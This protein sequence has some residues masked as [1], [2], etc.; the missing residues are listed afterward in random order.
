MNL[1]IFLLIIISVTFSA[2]AQ[3]VL[4]FGMTSEKIQ[5]VLDNKLNRLEV[6]LTIIGNTHVI[7]G[8]AIYGIGALLWLLVL[9]RLD[10]SQ[11]Y[12]FVGMGFILTMLFAF[13]F[14]GEPMKAARILGTL[15]VTAGVILI[16]RS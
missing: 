12:P 4:K 14:L 1:K 15:L 11:A 2:L 6:F 3:I 16:S 13:I 5:H 8:L 7:G 9:S 10:V